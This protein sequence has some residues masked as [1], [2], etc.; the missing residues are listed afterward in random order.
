[1]TSHIFKDFYTLPRILL[2]KLMEYRHLLVDHP[3]LYVGD[4]TYG[5]PLP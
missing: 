3:P 5:W 1:M 4:V 2:N